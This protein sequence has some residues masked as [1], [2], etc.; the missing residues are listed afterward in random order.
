MYG[1]SRHRLYL[2]CMIMT[3]R[4]YTRYITYT[5]STC[6]CACVSRAEYVFASAVENRTT[7]TTNKIHSAHIL[8]R[9]ESYIYLLLVVNYLLSLQQ[10]FKTPRWDDNSKPQLHSRRPGDTAFTSLRPTGSL[11]PRRSKYLLP[12]MT[13]HV[14]VQLRPCYTP[15]C[16]VEEWC[17]GAHLIEHHHYK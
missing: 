7:L 10:Q 6:M 8:Q 2:L 12:T 14:I 9:T 11:D 5:R 15:C 17:V 3:P 13:R 4:I 16:V 1:P